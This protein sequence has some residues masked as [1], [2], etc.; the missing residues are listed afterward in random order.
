[1]RYRLVLQMNIA[2]VD[3]NRYRNDIDCFVPLINRFKDIYGFYPE[4]PVADAGY[5][6]YNNYIFCEQN[7]MEKYMNFPMFRKKTTD[8][9]YHEPPSGQLIS[10]SVKMVLCGTRMEEPFICSTDGI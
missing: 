4:Y 3:V 1:M 2:V 9:N 8:K 5:G 10:Q 7:R 6:S